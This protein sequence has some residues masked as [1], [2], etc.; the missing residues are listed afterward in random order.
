MYDEDVATLYKY[1]GYGSLDVASP[2]RLQAAVEKFITSPST[3]PLVGAG[4]ATA[5]LISQLSKEGADLSLVKDG[6]KTFFNEMSKTAS[7]RMFRSTNPRVKEYQTL[8]NLEAD[9]KKINT[10]LYLK[11]SELKSLISEHKKEVG[12]DNINPKVV[13]EKINDFIN[14]KFKTQTT[15]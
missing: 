1:F 11:E 9:L 12:I 4:Y 7:R 14:E 3:N 2:K 8:D 10:E 5:E 13:P 15:G 6:Y